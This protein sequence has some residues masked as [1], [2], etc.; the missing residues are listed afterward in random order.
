MLAVFGDVHGN[1]A[2][3]EAV[4]ADIKRTGADE[5]VC[6]GDVASFGPQPRAT[7]RRVQALGCPVVM[8]NADWELLDTLTLEALKTSSTTFFDV[9][10]WCA[11]QLTDADRDFIRTFEPTVRLTFE[12]LPI[13][14]FHGSPKSYNDVVR[15]TTTDETLAE[16]FQE[17]A[18]LMFGGHT[19]TQLLRRFE[20]V[21]FVNPG[22]VGLPF[23]LL[24]GG[25]ARNPAW[26][27]YALVDVV[28]G[29]PSMTFR[30]V[31]YELGPLLEVARESGMPH[32]ETWCADWFPV[33]T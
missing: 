5:L 17:R 4:L 23:E 33:T 16:L 13:L 11:D 24:P 12:N 9:A 7:L 27:E 10:A 21:T 26:A 31:P 18:P 30:R 3:L 29:Q 22:S 25:E 32:A 14:C 2:A 1:L 20:E 28:H 8:G 15:A 19:H 6:L